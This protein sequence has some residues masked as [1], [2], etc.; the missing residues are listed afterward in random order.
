QEGLVVRD[1]RAR[2]HD[3]VGAGG[4]EI[5]EGAADL[6]GG[7]HHRKRVPA[8]PLLPE[9]FPQH[10]L[11]FVEGLAPVADGLAD[12]VDPAV[13]DGT[14]GVAPRRQVG[15]AEG[16]EPESEAGAQA[17]GEPEEPLEHQRPPACPIAGPRSTRRPTGQP[18]TGAGRRRAPPPPKPPSDRAA[19][20]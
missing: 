16:E 14:G 7:P 19:W 15:L 2:R 11:A 3:P 5:E 20:P 17:D 13:D 1:Q 8:L 18:S 6:L 12:P 4:E 9:A 10:R